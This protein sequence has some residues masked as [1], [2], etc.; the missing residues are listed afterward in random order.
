MIGYDNLPI[1]HQILLDLPFREAI[2]AITHDVAKPHHQDVDLI[3]TPTW[4]AL[5]SGLG[6]IDLNGTSEYLELAA[7]ACG[8][9]NFMSGDYSLGGWFNWASGDDSQ[10][11][12]GRYELDVGGWELYLYEDPNLYL[13]LRHHHAGTIVG[14]HPRSACYSGG[15]TQGVWHFMGVSRSG[16]S[17]VFYRN[18]VALATACSVGGLVDPETC[19]QDMVIGVRWDKGSNHFKGKLWR[20]RAWPRELSAEEWAKIFE[21]ERHWF[22]V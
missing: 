8:D 13:T 7:L 1:N 21:Y 4:E 9:L 16:S 11:I 2:R 19:A 15:W 10:I 5:A 3:D 22:G 20:P 6:V 12:I 17:A 14:D 18:G